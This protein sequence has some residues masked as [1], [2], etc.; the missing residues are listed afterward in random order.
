MTYTQQG[1]VRRRRKQILR[2]LAMLILLIGVSRARQYGV[3]LAQVK[4][5]VLRVL[6]G[7]VSRLAAVMALLKARGISILKQ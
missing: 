3:D 7:T 6:Q 2:M 4:S 1:L 5:L